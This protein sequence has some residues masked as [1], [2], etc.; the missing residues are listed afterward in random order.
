LPDL[1]EVDLRSPQTRCY[2][3]AAENKQEKLSKERDH[4]VKHIGTTL[5]QRI[6]R[7]LQRRKSIA[8]GAAEDGKGGLIPG[9][10]RR[11]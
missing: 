11:F 7:S 1:R 10:E 8:Q 3:N 9:I 5:H 4:E 2:K 6:T